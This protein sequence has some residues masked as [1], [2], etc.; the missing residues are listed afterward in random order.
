[1]DLGLTSELCQTVGDDSF[2]T[3]HIFLKVGKIQD[4]LSKMWQ[5]FGD[6]LMSLTCFLIFIKGYNL[7]IFYI[8][9]LIFEK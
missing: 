3:W 9:S 1:L 6:S 8:F 5:T 2:F 4:L 7:R